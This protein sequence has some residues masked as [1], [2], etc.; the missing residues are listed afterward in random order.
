MTSKGGNHIKK[1][2]KVSGLKTEVLAK[3]QIKLP[4]CNLHYLFQA[5]EK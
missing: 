1:R 2:Q 4:L 5:Y 3:D